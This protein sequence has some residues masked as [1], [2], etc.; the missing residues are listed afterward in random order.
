MCDA[1]ILI[2]IKNVTKIPPISKPR[3]QKL[4]DRHMHEREYCS[5]QQTVLR[6]SIFTFHCHAHRFATY[7]KNNQIFLRMIFVFTASKIPEMKKK[8]SIYF[9]CI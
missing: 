9:E 1:K 4:T 7:I 2:E 5:N 6:D 3:T 8:R